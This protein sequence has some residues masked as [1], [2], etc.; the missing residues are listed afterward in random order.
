MAPAL[1]RQ[2]VA[3]APDP[4]RAR[5]SAVLIALFPEAGSWH[6]I[7]IERG[8]YDGVHSG[9]IALPGGRMDP[10]DPDAEFTALREAEEEVAVPRQAVEVLGRL[11][12]LYVPASGHVIQPVVGRLDHKPELRP[13]PSE[14]ASIITVS[15]EQ[16]FAPHIKDKRMRSLGGGFQLEAPHYHIEG[17]EIWGA[18]AMIISELESLFERRL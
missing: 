15:L 16:L 18:T 11:T 13:E 4:Q 3:L 6:T 8:T 1:R 5:P 17:H 9:Q 10:E 12:E 7:F 14:V 2:E